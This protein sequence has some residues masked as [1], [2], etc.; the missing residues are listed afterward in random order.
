M[1]NMFKL[2]DF[3]IMNMLNPVLVFDR[4]DELRVCNAAAERI[5]LVKKGISL[6]DFIQGSDL[7]YILSKER[8]EQGR[9]KEFTLT[10]LKEKMAFLI[11]G[12]ELYD[13][14]GVYV[15]M[16][17]IYNDISGQE[18]LK[19]EATYHATRDH[20]TGLWN[21]DFFVEMV[22]KTLRENPDIKFVLIATDIYQFKMFNDV[23][24]RKMGDDVLL[25]IT[26]A[27]LETSRT[28]WVQSRIA[29]DR[30]AVLIPEEDFDEAKILSVMNA[31]L[32]K[33]QYSLK[34][35]NYI[36]VYH[37]TDRSL[38]VEAMYDRA[39]MA[40]ESIK[41]DFQK[42]IAYYEDEMRNRK[43]KDTLTMEELDYA[44]KSEQLV[45][46]LQPQV[47]IMNETVVGCEALVRW[48]HPTRG[49]VPPFEFIPLFEK[50]G[51]IIRMDYHVWELACKQLAEW[52]MAGKKMPSISV[53]ISA[54]DFYLC[55]LYDDIVGLVERYGIEPKRLRLEITESA[56]ALD[57][58]EQMEIV[59]RLQE[60]GFIVEMDDFGSGY[61]S[62]NNLKEITVDIMKLDMK[63]FKQTANVERA[64]KIVESVVH[65][66]KKIKMPM[67]AEGVE[68]KEQ[69]EMLKRIGCSMVQ[70]YYYAAPM[71]VDEF[72]EFMERNTLGDLSESFYT[73]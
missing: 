34:L 71:S 41:G 28:L 5:L 65:L 21:R 2:K 45:M 23:L 49:M 37:I 68:T 50:N 60:Y 40:L 72:E 14:R 15:G 38:H 43:L 53:N 8:R 18:R 1:L 10:M 48:K 6:D 63:F 55:D 36:G 29:A 67:I 54:R 35:H 11:H 66:A 20:L 22:A 19:D 47:N 32:N 26:K 46:Y 24:G 3:A 44:L 17:M 64:E 59:S 62:L 12:Q 42:E 52:Q 9:T 58:Q 16:L 27:L 73:E 30:F 31:V 13:S 69:V 33:K 70:G 57:V 4:Q 51:M 39:R 25:S 7:K 56:L 61:S